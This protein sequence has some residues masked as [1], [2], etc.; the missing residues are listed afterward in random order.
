MELVIFAICLSVV[1]VAVVVGVI[2][3]LCRS[4]NP[5]PILSEACL[6]DFSPRNCSAVRRGNIS[7]RVRRHCENYTIE[8]GDRA[9]DL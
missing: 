6:I 2:E 7:N 1:V 9:S 8:L 5:I 4:I 3:P